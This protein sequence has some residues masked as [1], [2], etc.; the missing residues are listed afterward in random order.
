MVTPSER[1][2]GDKPLAALAAATAC[3][4]IL[5]LICFFTLKEIEKRVVSAAEL[6]FDRYTSDTANKI[7]G[8]LTRY[9]DLLP[10]MK[11]MWALVSSPTR[12]QFQ[13]YSETLHVRNRFPSLLNVNYVEYTPTGATKAFQKQ[14]RVADHRPDFRVY[15]NQTPY[16]IRA[17]IRFG[18]PDAVSHIGRDILV[19]FDQGM[20]VFEVTAKSA[21]PFGSGQAVSKEDKS[22]HPAIAFRLA[23]YRTPAT[24][25]ARRPSARYHWLRRNLR[26][27]LRPDWRGAATR[28]LAVLDASPSVA[29]EFG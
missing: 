6:R 8:Q 13:K 2:A 11:G 1:R 26:R 23:V 10:G 9:V 18:D 25:P 4:V 22:G 19:N 27:R 15:P 28:G 5:A 12:E 21:E 16:P 3:L 29:R 14:I 17:V 20:H 24:P 7:A